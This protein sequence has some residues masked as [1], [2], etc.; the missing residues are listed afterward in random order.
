MNNSFRGGHG[1]GP[2]GGGGPGGMAFQNDMSQQQQQQQQPFG[3]QQQRGYPPHMMQQPPG[4][5]Q[6]Q[7]HN[8]PQ[9]IQI[10]NSQ[11]SQRYMSGGMPSPSLVQPS[12]M[13]GYPGTSGSVVGSNP[14][15]TQM[16][17]GPPVR[18]VDLAPKSHH[19]ILRKHNEEYA[20]RQTA[21]N[22]V[23]QAQGLTPG[24][25]FPVP[26]AKHNNTIIPVLPRPVN[27]YPTNE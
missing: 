15:A 8:M 21:S 10:P 12:S 24:T 23:N 13:G 27:P 3:F 16:P 22:A 6:Q 7:P 17:F 25:Y 11:Q 4:Q 1:R 26:K 9:Q 19:D 14:N 18:P 2:R 20:S 5:Q